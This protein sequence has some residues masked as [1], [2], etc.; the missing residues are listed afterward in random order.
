MVLL[1][2]LLLVLIALDDKGAERIEGGDGDGDDCDTTQL[3]SPSHQCESHAEQDAAP[4]SE[5]EPES[6]GLQVEEPLALEEPAGQSR[7]GLP[8]EEYL[9]AAHGLQ[10]VANE[11]DEY[12]SG[13]AVQL[14][15]PIDA[16]VP[17][18]Q[19]EQLL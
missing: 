12:P 19:G 13:H 4:G 6:Q 1:V 16:N 3:A 7:Q 10:S 8:R 17:A 15:A 2:I 5:K 9:P 11:D 14:E 18:R